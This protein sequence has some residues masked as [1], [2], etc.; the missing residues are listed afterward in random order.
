MNVLK[1]HK[2]SAV[3]TLLS[4]RIS[5]RQIHKMTGVDRKTIREIEAEISNSSM[6]TGDG[7]S[8]N[9]IPPPR[10]PAFTVDADI[11]NSVIGASACEP[12]RAF[13]EEQIGLGRNATAI[14][15]DL[16]DHHKFSHA[17]NSVKRFCRNLK[18]KEPEQFDRLE[19]LPGEEAQV[20]YGEGAPTLNPKTGKYRKPRLFV[21]T[22]RFSRRSFR[23]VVWKSSKEVWAKL[24]E[25]AFLYF[26]G[27][28]MF[29]VLDNLKEGVITPD[30]YEP[31]LNPLYAELLSHYGAVADPARVRDPDRKG[32]VENA[33]QHTQSTA[34]KGRRFESIEVQN[35]FLFHWEENWA[36]K[37]IHG[38]A[39]RQVEEMFQ[40]EKPFLKNLPVE[41]FAIFKEESRTVQDDGTVNV[42]HVYYA[43]RPASIGAKVTVRIFEYAITIHENSTLKVLRRHSRSY[44]KGA[45]FL[46]EEE[47]IYNPSR[48]THGILNEAGRIGV[49]TRAL[50]ESLFEKEG[51]IGH[52]RMRGIISLASKNRHPAYR[53]E[54]EC[55]R[56][57]E[58]GITSYQTI[59]RMV[60]EAGK[61]EIK[62]KES[63]GPELAQ[64]D[65]L[66]RDPQEYFE[67]WNMYKNSDSKSGDAGDGSDQALH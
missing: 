64:T 1:N 54:A 41:T 48:Q 46:P 32:T 53:V 2:K 3:L 63:T 50:C 21:M 65:P 7:V 31:L 59:K 52:K 49:A 40:E 9:Q 17:Y 22:L 51:R 44:K 20:D 11:K 36:A 25:E 19:F 18:Q 38:R 12:H 57:I 15:Q 35:E 62:T 42:D 58:M 23:K 13:L 66:I 8:Q 16:V 39:K 45:V 56:A 34:L 10:P 30:L 29:I 37:R 26:G 60:E 67:F 27:V 61:N 14:Y 4:R 55:V 33:I 5:Q 6:A 43:A 28:P 47:R 24:H